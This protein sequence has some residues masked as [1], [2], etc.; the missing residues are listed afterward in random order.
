MIYF[1]SDM[2]FD[3]APVIELCNR[4][5]N[6]VLEMNETLIANWNKKVTDKDEVYI[7]GDIG[8]TRKWVLLEPHLK[9]LNGKKHLIRG[10]HDGFL[11]DKKFDNTYFDKVKDYYELKYRGKLFILSHYPMCDWKMKYNGAIH[12]YGHI[13]ANDSAFLQAQFGKCYHV[14]VDSNNF[15]PVSIEEVIKYTDHVSI[16]GY[17]DALYQDIKVNQWGHK[18][19]KI[20]QR[21][22]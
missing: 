22:V 15:S 6:T 19:R 18:A 9:K 17:F 10:N 5:F 7:L 4:P 8:M 12:L 21:G 11:K 1:T 13:H 14:G 2:H 3:Y 20:D 16:T